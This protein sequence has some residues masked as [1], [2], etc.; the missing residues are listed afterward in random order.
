ML[1][2]TGWKKSNIWHLNEYFLIYISNP[3]SWQIYLSKFV[4]D[5]KHLY[6]LIGK[7]II[8]HIVTFFHPLCKTLTTNADI[9]SSTTCASDSYLLRSPFPG[10]FAQCVPVLQLILLLHG[11]AR[12]WLPQWL[13]MSLFI[14][15]SPREWRLLPSVS[16]GDFL[17][18][19]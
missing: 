8:S 2:I 10:F 4:T 15:L 7:K 14:P 19:L 11:K 16:H 6:P 13:C 18:V 3:Y 17:F 9:C 12:L 1:P 5:T